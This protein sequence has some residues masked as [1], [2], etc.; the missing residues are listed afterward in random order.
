MEVDVDESPNLNVL[1][2]ELTSEHLSKLTKRIV[3]VTDL[4]TLGLEV[5]KLQDFE[6][7]TAVENNKRIEEQA[8]HVLSTWREKQPT[9][10]EAYR[11]LYTGLVVHEDWKR[12][13]S[14]LQQWVEGGAESSGLST[15]ATT[16]GPPAGKQ[17][18][19][20]LRAQRELTSFPSEDASPCDTVGAPPDVEND[21]APE[22]PPESVTQALRRPMTPERKKHVFPVN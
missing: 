3:S 8:Y 16:L 14:D 12:L 13:A 7:D 5:L 17:E 21:R 1:A 4:R 18:P 2:D 9:G 22:Q 20:P 11:A 6:V 10:E 19:E 15:A